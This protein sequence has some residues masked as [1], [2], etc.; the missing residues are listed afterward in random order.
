[1]MTAEEFEAAFAAMSGVTVAF[2]HRC[3]RYAEPC[4][5]GGYGCQ[6]WWMGR[7]WEDAIM[8]DRLRAAG[9]EPPRNPEA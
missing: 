4:R 2:L 6:G 1:M 8:E 5:C 3:G 9:R 7:Q